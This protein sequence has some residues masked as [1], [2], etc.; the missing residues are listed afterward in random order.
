[1]TAGAGAIIHLAMEDA[2]AQRKLI[3]R[4]ARR[5]RQAGRIRSPGI[6]MNAFRRQR[7]IRLGDNVAKD[8]VD[9]P[10]GMFY[11][12]KGS[13]VHYVC[14]V[15]SQAVCRCSQSHVLHVLRS[16]VI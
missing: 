16:P 5:Q 10:L 2:L 11:Y 8:I 12:N 1:M 14:L 6:G 15:H 7:I 13:S 3:A 9:E 4:H